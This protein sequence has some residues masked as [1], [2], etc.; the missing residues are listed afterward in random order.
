[1]KMSLNVHS[2]IRF[3]VFPFSRSFL[4]SYLSFFC[5]NNQRLHYLKDVFFTSESPFLPF[6]L[7]T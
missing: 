3:T 1:M 2:R 7:R 6:N 4:H 5:D